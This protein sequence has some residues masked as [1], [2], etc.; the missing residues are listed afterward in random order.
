[1]AATARRVA[2]LK[3]RF[4]PSYGTPIGR[5]FDLLG[6]LQSSSGPPTEASA[7][8]LDASTTE[9]RDAITKLNEIITTMMPAVR[10]RIGTTSAQTEP[11][12][13]P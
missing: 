6:A 4:S 10:S 5:A 3:P 11:V 2:E 1:V 8:I 9:L 12:R 13:V 7:R